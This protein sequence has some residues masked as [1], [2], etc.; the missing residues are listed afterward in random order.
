MPIDEQPDH[1][2]RAILEAIRASSPT[3]VPEIADHL[4]AHPATVERRCLELQKNGYVRQ[5]TGGKFVVADHVESV[6]HFE[7][8]LGGQVAGD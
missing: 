8:D 5:C 1:Q 2:E 3:T 4:S 7:S 6:D